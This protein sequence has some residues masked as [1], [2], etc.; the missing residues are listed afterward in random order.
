MNQPFD[1]D[2]VIT[3]VQIDSA[4]VGIAVNPQCSKYSSFSNGFVVRC[5]LTSASIPTLYQCCC[6]VV[7]EGTPAAVIKVPSV[8]PLLLRA[9]ALATGMSTSET[10][11]LSILMAPKHRDIQCTTTA[12]TATDRS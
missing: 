5:R 6:C 10:F 9:A 2:I 1:N 3:A 11:T 12:A 4:A 8:P 7:V